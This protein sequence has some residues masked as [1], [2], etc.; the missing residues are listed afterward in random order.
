MCNHVITECMSREIKFWTND[1]VTFC[2]PKCTR[3][4]LVKTDS[5]LASVESRTRLKRASKARHIYA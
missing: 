3:R 1:V 5:V 2:K 4:E